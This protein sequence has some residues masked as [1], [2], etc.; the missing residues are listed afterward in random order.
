MKAIKLFIIFLVIFLSLETQ[1]QK[2]NSPYSRFGLGQLR[3]ENVNTALMGMG[4]I[5]I[6]IADPT[7]INPGNAASYAVYDSTSFIFEI[8]VT[9]NATNLKTVLQSESSSYFA[10]NY[11]VFGFPI[12]KWWKSSLGMLPYS[13]IGYDV[14]IYIPVEGFSNVINSIEGDGG[15]NQFYWG[16][17]F[18]IG[19]NLRLGFDA[20]YLFG[21]GSRSSLIYFPDSVNIFGTKTIAHT[22]GGDIIFDYGAQYDIKIKTDK[23]LTLGLIYSNNWNVKAKREYLSYTLTGGYGEIV[24]TLQ[25]T[26]A[27]S[28]EEKGTVIIPQRFGGGFTFQETGRWLIGAD[29]EWQNW[30]KYTSFGT[31]DSLDNSWRIAVGGQFT[32]KH[33]SISS[34]TKRM[35]YRLGFRYY[36]S[37]LSI[38]DTP[39]NEY[40]ISFGLTFPMKKTKTAID[41]GVEIG[42]RGTTANNLIQENFVNISLGFSIHEHWFHKRRYQ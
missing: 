2:I 9:G 6:G 39:I 5:S 35:T 27:Y 29:F 24:E 11:I 7:M 14:K 32:P 3:S 28:P 12:T 38:F 36:D 34:L 20:I 13:Q 15:L 4:G 19:E 10:L 26:I 23:L 1:A 37:Y 18:K 42:K 17:A 25:D 30:E 21:Q 41:L 22:R 31:T 8:G 40:G 16:N 33:T